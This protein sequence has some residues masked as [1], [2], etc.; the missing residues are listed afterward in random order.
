MWII[1]GY[2]ALA[3]L[4][5][6]ANVSARKIEK[7]KGIIYVYPFRC[8]ICYTSLYYTCLSFLSEFTNIPERNPTIYIKGHVIILYFELISHIY[9]G[10]S[11]W[12]YG[13]L[14][15]SIFWLCHTFDFSLFL[16]SFAPSMLST[17]V[18][19]HRAAKLTF[20]GRARKSGASGLL[21]FYSRSHLRVLRWDIF[22]RYCQFVR[23]IFS[24]NIESNFISLDHRKAAEGH[25]SFSCEPKMRRYTLSKY[26]FFRAT[27][28]VEQISFRRDLTEKKRKK[29]IF[30]ILMA[31]SK[32][33]N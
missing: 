20:P 15:L 4:G 6:Y 30:G 14:C 27:F 21:S 17:K 18:S 28:L 16:P 12:C 10:S 7:F 5:I 11:Y 25:P 8:H 22:S 26:I 33:S 3:A 32:E 19:S 1:V 29:G 23:R 2:L 9:E 13:S 24:Q 31:A